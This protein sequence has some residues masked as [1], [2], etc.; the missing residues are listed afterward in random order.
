M[1]K[2][3]MRIVEWEG[4]MVRLLHLGKM[5][6]SNSRYTYSCTNVS[7]YNPCGREDCIGEGSGT[8]RVEEGIKIKMENTWAKLSTIFI[9]NND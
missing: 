7:D 6:N 2:K 1:I 5:L 9:S 4:R 8:K 3:K